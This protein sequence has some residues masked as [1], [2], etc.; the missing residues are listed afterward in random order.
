MQRDSNETVQSTLV[1]QM[2]SLI[3]A[4]AYL[5]RHCSDRG[6]G[7]ADRIFSAMQGHACTKTPLAN[8]E[9]DSWEWETGKRFL[10][11]L[12]GT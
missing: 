7:I 11:A 5:Y 12:S 2:D 1:T 4:I 9:E 6:A 8:S 10:N 3:A